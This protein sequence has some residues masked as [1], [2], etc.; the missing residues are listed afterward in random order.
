M[1]LATA[2]VASFVA[3]TKVK[4][5]WVTP[6]DIKRA[7]DPSGDAVSKEMVQSYVKARFGDSLLPKT[8]LREHIADAMVCIDVLNL[9]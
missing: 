6:T 2:V 3:Q 9:A 5:I 7:V 1:A 8:G 4:F